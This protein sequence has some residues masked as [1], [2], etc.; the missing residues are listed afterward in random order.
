MFNCLFFFLVKQLPL[1]GHGFLPLEIPLETN[2]VA[3][4]RGKLLPT[5][6]DQ[7]QGEQRLLSQTKVKW[8]FTS[9]WDHL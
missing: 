8:T 3:A 2:V 4:Y 9:V 7:L 6:I 5:R 1:E